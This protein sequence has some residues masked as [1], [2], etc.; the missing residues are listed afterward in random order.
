MHDTTD[1]SAVGKLPYTFLGDQ[2]WRYAS[3][4]R[5]ANIREPRYGDMVREALDYVIAQRPTPSDWFDPNTTEF[6]DQPIRSA[7]DLIF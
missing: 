7:A 5:S 6:V 2:M 3:E 4:L 1:N